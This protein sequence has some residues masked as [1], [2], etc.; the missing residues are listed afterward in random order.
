MRQCYLIISSM[1]RDTLSLNETHEKE[2][3]DD[4]YITIPIVKVLLFIF[5]MIIGSFLCV[6]LVKSVLCEI[7]EI[8]LSP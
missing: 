4:C 1:S 5:F 2:N 7:E 6:S 8:G 3:F